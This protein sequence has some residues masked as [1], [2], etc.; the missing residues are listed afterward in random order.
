MIVNIMS[1]LFVVI[2]MVL[3]ILVSSFVRQFGLPNTGIY[4]DYIV[5]SFLVFGCLR[6]CGVL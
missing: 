2:V 1:T 6:L 4:K 3:F 5:F